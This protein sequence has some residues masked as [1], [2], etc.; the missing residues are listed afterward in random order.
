MRVYERVSDIR[1][2][3][4]E[5]RRTGRTVGFVPTMGALHAGHLSLMQASRNDCGATAVS[6]FVNPTQFGPHEDFQRYP[7]PR[8]ADLKLCE[9]AGVDLVFYPQVE[10]MYP[11][12]PQTF[13]EVAG[14]SDVWEGAIRPGHFRGVA[15]VV[16]KLFLA[17]PAEKAYFGQKDYQQQLILRRMVRDLHFPV[18]IVTCPIL[19]DTDGLALS[20]RNAYLS[21]DERRAAL[22]IPQALGEAKRAFDKGQRNPRALQKLLMARLMNEPGLTADYAVVV[23]AQTLA[24]LDAPHQRMVALVAA[25]AGKT[26][27]IDN[28]ILETTH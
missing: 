17:V 16:A 11:A 1:A 27:L 3:V 15:T 21:P 22:A 25:R 9:Q 26:R 8:N 2:A 28:E 20:S 10:E 18:E 14:L 24:E 7:R 23:D 19:R 12:G 6:I 4:T 5:L 13:V